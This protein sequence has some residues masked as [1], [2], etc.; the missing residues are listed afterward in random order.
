MIMIAM[1]KITK[2][3]KAAKSVMHLSS[4]NQRS[5]AVVKL[6]TAAHLAAYLLVT[7]SQMYFKPRQM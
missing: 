3:V 4:F 6:L 1:M 7:L 5:Q 2:H